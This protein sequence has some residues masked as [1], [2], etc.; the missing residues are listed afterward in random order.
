[1]TPKS[2]KAWSLDSGPTTRASYP[3]IVEGGRKEVEGG[4]G[5]GGAPKGVCPSARGEAGP[6]QRGEVFRAV[7]LDLEGLEVWGFRM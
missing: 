6:S 7:G 5:G 3:T 1:M 4:G 2:K